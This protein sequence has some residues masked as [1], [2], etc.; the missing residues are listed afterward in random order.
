MGDENISKEIGDKVVVGVIR[1]HR[2]TSLLAR[3]QT[4]AHQ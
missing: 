3:G 1:T 2:S 4:E